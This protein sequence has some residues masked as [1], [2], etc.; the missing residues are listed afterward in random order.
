MNEFNG[1]RPVLNGWITIHA[2][3]PPR[4]AEVKLNQVGMVG[5]AFGFS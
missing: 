3:I 4:P 5:F 1:A 2:K